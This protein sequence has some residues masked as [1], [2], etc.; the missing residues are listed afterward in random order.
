MRFETYLGLVLLIEFDPDGGYL[1]PLEVGE[2]DGPPSLGGPGH[3]SEHELED[4]LFAEGVGN[5]L[6]A[7]AFLEEQALQ[8]IGRAGRP[9][10]GD[11]HPRV[12]DAGLE[13]IHKASDRARQLG[14]I[15][16]DQAI[17]EISGD[18]PAGGLIGRL[19]VR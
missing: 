18:R 6:E 3:G 1:A 15:V 12:R 9:A 10:V 11:G 8:E 17:G 2:L 5:D 13:V 4:G 19:G 14:F 16:A 7:P